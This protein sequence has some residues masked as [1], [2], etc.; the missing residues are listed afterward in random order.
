M[1]IKTKRAFIHRLIEVIWHQ[2]ELGRI[3]EFYSVE[4]L[5]KYPT[6][7]EDVR[8]LQAAFPDVQVKIRGMVAE[9]DTVAIRWLL[10]G[11]HKGEF[12]NFHPSNNQV[13]VPGMS[14]I[15][16]SD[17]KVVDIRNQFD[18]LNFMQQLGSFSWGRRSYFYLVFI[19]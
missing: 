17:G 10:Q 3:D 12:M 6:H 11:T 18:L 1:T 9:E 8:S 5:S 7:R 19:V 16:V 4:F 14:F 2:R 13:R 15:Q